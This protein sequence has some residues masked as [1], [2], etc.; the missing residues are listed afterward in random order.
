MSIY[1]FKMPGWE[2]YSTWGEDMGCLYAQLY[3][4]HGE[5]RDPPRVWITQPNHQPKTVN[6]LAE[7]VAEA[8]TRFEVVTVPPVVVRK[9]L[10]DGY[11]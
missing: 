3:M 6:E 2:R 9:W 5:P 7:V 10:L 11:S 1:Q 8:V 4:N